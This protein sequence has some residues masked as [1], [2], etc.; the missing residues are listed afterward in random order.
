MGVGVPEGFFMNQKFAKE[1]FDIVFSA[2]DESDPEDGDDGEGIGLLEELLHEATSQGVNITHVF[3]QCYALQT[4]YMTEDAIPELNQLFT[5]D[6]S[7]LPPE[8]QFA[9]RMLETQKGSD[10]WSVESFGTALRVVYDVL[11]N[12]L[13]KARTALPSLKKEK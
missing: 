13:V 7:Q 2:G 5:Q 6:R 9:F 11:N 12:R 8:R 4:E 3:L 1:L 10:L